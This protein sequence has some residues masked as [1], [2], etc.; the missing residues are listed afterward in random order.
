MNPL[1]VERAQPL[2]DE[3]VE[4]VRERRLLDFVVALE[5]IEGI[6][7]GL[8]NL[9]ANRSRGDDA[10][11]ASRMALTIVWAKSELMR[12]SA[13]R[14]CPKNAAGSTTAAVLP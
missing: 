9:R 3:L 6:G 8:R 12:S 10:Q 4:C 13:S 14:S 7:R 2:V 11:N 5:E 1:D